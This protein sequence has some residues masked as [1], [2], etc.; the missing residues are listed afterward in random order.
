MKEKGVAL[1]E[2]GVCCNPQCGAPLYRELMAAA[3]S[4]ACFECDPQQFRE[5]WHPL[6]TKYTRE[7]FFDDSHA[8]A[9]PVCSEAC[10]SRQQREGRG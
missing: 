2:V 10:C 5:G 1:I 3:D 4:E 8:P 6:M 9:R 7:P